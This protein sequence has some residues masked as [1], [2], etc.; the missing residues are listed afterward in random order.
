MEK[1]SNYRISTHRTHSIDVIFLD[2]LSFKHS[3]GRLDFQP[4]II[5]VNMNFAAEDNIIT[6]YKG[7]NQSFGHCPV[8][9]VRLIHPIMGLFHKTDFGVVAHKITTALQQINKIPL[10]LFII[11][12]IIKNRT[13]L[14][15][16]PSGAKYS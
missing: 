9:I 7:I 1:V 2:W 3:A 11:R 5:H 12:R 15:T 6:V 14:K 13:F 8:T 16:I 10:K 4:V